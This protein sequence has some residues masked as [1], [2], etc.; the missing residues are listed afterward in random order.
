MLSAATADNGNR[1]TLALG[2]VTALVDL[3]G[4]WSN[5]YIQR[6]TAR[7]QVYAQALQAIHRYEELPYAIRHRQGSDGEARTT[8]A[9]RISDVFADVNYHQTLLTMDS[10]VVGKAYEGLFARTRQHG[11]PHRR[12]AWNTPPMSDDTDVPGGAY[13]PYDNG[14]ER[15]LCLLAMR[16]ELRPWSYLARP[17]TLRRLRA[18][19]DARPPWRGPEWMQRRREEIIG[20]PREHQQNSG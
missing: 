7:S 17:A 18:L 9:A 12:E 15:E 4:Y 13:Y 16:R 3:I 6:S 10:A 5:L 19:Q 8:L 11:G 14:P 1:L 20:H 2:M